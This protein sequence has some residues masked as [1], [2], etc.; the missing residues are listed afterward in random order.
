MNND[1]MHEVLQ[2]SLI[3]H[4]ALTQL[5]KTLEELLELEI[6]IIKHLKDPTHNVDHIREEIV[7]V[8]IML[9]QLSF[10]FDHQKVGAVLD[11]KMNRL[12]DMVNS[13]D[14]TDQL[15]TIKHSIANSRNDIADLIRD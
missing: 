3:K 11:K 14:Y 4:G 1:R 2:E 12:N 6:E 7:D 15:P 9:G 13:S 8:W 5:Y 10:L